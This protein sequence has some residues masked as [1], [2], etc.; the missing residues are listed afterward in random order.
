MTQLSQS[1][2]KEYLPPKTSENFKSIPE[3]VYL[4]TTIDGQELIIDPTIAQYVAGYDQIFFGTRAELKTLIMH[5]TTQFTGSV[6]GTR[7]Q[8]FLRYWGNTSM[9]AW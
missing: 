8:I 1:A 2:N 6:A 3:H 7:E 5:P 4:T 9:P